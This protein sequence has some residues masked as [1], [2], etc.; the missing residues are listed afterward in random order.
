[1]T[2]DAGATNGPSALACASTEQCTV[3]DTSGREA[4][5]NPSATTAA[6]PTPIDSS[7]LSG[8]ACPSPS[9]CA[10]VDVSG[11]EVTF[12]PQ[13]PGI[14]QP[15]TIDSGAV[16]HSV[17]CPSTSECVAVDDSSREVIFNPSSP[18]SAV[19]H[20]IDSPHLLYNV[21]CPSATQCSATDEI[22]RLVTFNPK[23]PG[24]PTPAFV[25]TAGA[26]SG[27]ACSSVST[28]V[29]ADKRSSLQGGMVVHAGG[30]VAFDPKAPGTTAPK[31]IDPS[32]PLFAIACPSGNQCTAVGES[33]HAYTFDP[34]AIGSPA[35]ATLQGTSSLVAIACPA[36]SECVAIDAL[37]KR[38]V[39]AGHQ[40]RPPS[41]TVG[42]VTVKGTVATI[43]IA[44]ARSSPSSCLV[45]LTLTVKQH[46]GPVG[47]RSLSLRAG[48]RKTVKLSLD[49][50]GR[51]LLKKHRDLS[52]T[53]TVHVADGHAT[54]RTLSFKHR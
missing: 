11:R 9:L 38:F 26:V 30:V 19:L 5:F 44:C 52:V 12:N 20:T 40:G 33:E 36:V 16:L 45:R 8:I 48:H 51:K 35:P 39:G 24:T 29:A 10:A 47:K 41:A 49:G 14:P 3:V 15:K 25:D 23:S 17:A 4:A 18:A 43:P 27:L 34:T 13:A 7:Q 21:S 46:K 42:H 50:A 1:M 31:Q 28:C 6:P 2:V 54:T 22:Q 32:G 37:G 53:L